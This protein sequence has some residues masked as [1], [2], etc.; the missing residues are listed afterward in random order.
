M[1]QAA[2]GGERHRQGHSGCQ[3]R[4]RS[5]V[6]EEARPHCRDPMAELVYGKGDRRGSV[7]ERATKRRKAAAERRRMI[8]G[9]RPLQSEKGK[10]D[11]VD[12]LRLRVVEQLHIGT[13]TA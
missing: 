2:D 7:E 8:S 9:Q 4:E 10:E 6:G 11:Y 13:C 3:H 1:R 5:S 12:Q